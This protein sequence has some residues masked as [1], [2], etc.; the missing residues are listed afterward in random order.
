[1][2]YTLCC[3]FSRGN[4][5][6]YDGKKPNERGTIERKNEKSIYANSHSDSTSK[7]Q[8]HYNLLQKKNQNIQTP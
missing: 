2:L 8:S 6:L 3:T 4:S 7:H 5:T 1:M